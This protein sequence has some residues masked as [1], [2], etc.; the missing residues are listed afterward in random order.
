MNSCPENLRD[1]PETALQPVDTVE[2]SFWRLS[3]YCSCGLGRIFRAH[4]LTQGD[5][6]VFLSECLLPS[7]LTAQLLARMLP[8][9]LAYFSSCRSCSSFDPILGDDVTDQRNRAATAWSAAVFPRIRS[10][11]WW[12]SSA[13]TFPELARFP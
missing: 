11:L 12:P 5:D 2:S 9:L 4:S 8:C 7:F 10:G 6:F 13:R 1:E 3:R